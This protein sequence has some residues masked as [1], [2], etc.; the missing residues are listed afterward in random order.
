MLALDGAGVCVVWC[1]LAA[2]AL[3][4]AF[5]CCDNRILNSWQLSRLSLFWQSA[6]IVEEVAGAFLPTFDDVTARA[7]PCVG[8]D[9]CDVA[10]VGNGQCNPR[11]NVTECASRPPVAVDWTSLLVRCCFCGLGFPVL[12]AFVVVV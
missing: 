12:C 1:P 4:F 2:T 9:G 5:A 11:C 8:V 3:H 10:E 6:A 7:A